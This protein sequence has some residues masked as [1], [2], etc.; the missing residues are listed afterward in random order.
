[1]AEKRFHKELFPDLEVFI[2]PAHV[3]N[4]Q[5]FWVRTKA[6]FLLVKL[7]G[8][9]RFFLENV[10]GS[11]C[12]FDTKWTSE[13]GKAIIVLET[14][15]YFFVIYQH[16]NDFFVFV[17]NCNMQSFFWFNNEIKILDF[18]IKFC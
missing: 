1:M 7:L 13:W 6:Y 12:I 18:E 15:I 9:G 4:H 3:K 14:K 8:S 5:K 11:F 17:H 10:L 16:F 2:N